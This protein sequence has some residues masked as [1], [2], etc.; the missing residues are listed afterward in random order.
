MKKTS[1]ALAL[2]LAFS[3]HGY[4][5]SPQP[6]QS[7][8]QSPVIAAS[9]STAQESVAYAFDGNPS[10]VWTLDASSLKH[11]QWLM[12]TIGNPGDVQSITISQKGASA[13]QLK[14]ALEVYVTYDP[15]NLGT[16]VDFNVSTEKGN[17]VL[18][19]PAKYGAHVR[20][21]VKPD[22]ITRPWSLAELAVGIAAAASPVDEAGVDRSYLDTSLPVDRRIEILLAQ[23]TPE[24]KMELIREGWGIPGVPRL[25]IPDIKKVEAIHGYSYGTGATMFPQVLGMAA[26]WN[27]P[28]LYKVTEAIGR[29][30]LEAGSIA[31]WSPVLDVAIDPRWGRCEESF[32]EAPY[33]CSALGK[34]WVNGYQR[35][36]LITTPKHFGA[37]GA[38]LGGRDSHD[39]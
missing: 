3:A 37:H 38:P 21:A 14:R 2:G 33:L 32:G 28:L 1:F 23:M 29:E 16:P 12:L 27:R 24:E 17:T 5:K 39:V 30:S 10:T 22:V 25:G 4:C 26:S 35:L 6:S 34:A 9:S 20:I 15:M 31:A 11:P 8:V 36:G 18:T 13:E 7:T 19:F